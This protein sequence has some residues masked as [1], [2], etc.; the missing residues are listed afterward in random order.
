LQL[1]QLGHPWHLH[2]HKREKVYGLFAKKMKKKKK[3]IYENEKG[4]RDQYELGDHK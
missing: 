1:L 3:K 4:N 2:N